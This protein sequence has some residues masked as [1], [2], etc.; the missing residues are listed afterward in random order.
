ME[1][2]D[3]LTYNTRK[4]KLVLPEYG[5]NVHRMIEYCAGI[6][7][8]AERTRC[9]HA[10]VNIMGNLFPHLRDIDDFKHKLWDHLAIMSDFKLDID[11]PCEVI[12]RE[13]LNDKPD[14]VPYTTTGIRYRHYGKLLE[15]MLHKW[16]EMPEG[17]ERSQ[18]IVY[19]ANH[20]KKSMA[21]WNK[22]A[23]EDEKIYKD[24]IEY[25]GNRVPIEK[26]Q[27]RLRELPK[28]N[29]MQRKTKNNGKKAG[30]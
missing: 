8:R 25:T 30:R 10:I 19:L 24:I 23:V 21:A 20:M 12:R 27:L 14:K 13:K 28:E 26:E 9:A 18:L 3:L 29:N 5:R 4:K 22:E 6:E 7:D 1:Q 2:E 17:E 16:E 15:E 11:Y